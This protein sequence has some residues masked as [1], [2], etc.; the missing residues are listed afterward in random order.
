MTSAREWGITREERAAAVRAIQGYFERER[1]ETLGDL[2]AGLFLDFIAEELGHLFYNRALLDAQA[3]AA[4][5][6]DSLEADLDAQRRLPPRG[7][8]V[9]EAPR[10]PS[11]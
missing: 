10:A 3:V 5:H 8:V 9:T 2:G 4:R 1:G 6:A 7:W 11:D